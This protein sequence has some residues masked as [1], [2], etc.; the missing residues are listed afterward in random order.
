MRLQAHR[1]ASLEFAL[2]LLLGLLWG[3][4]YALTKISL[5]TIPPLSL[6][7]GRVAL[8]AAALWTVVAFR[9]RAIPRTQEFAA[10]LFIQGAL[11]C[12]LPYTLI[13]FGQQTVE[14]GLAAILNSATPV[15][16]CI[17]SVLW[18][19]QE[20]LSRRRIVGVVVGFSGVIGIT[21]A[22]ALLGFGQQVPGQAAIILA[23]LSSALSV[24]HGRHF[25]TVAPEVV[26]AGML[27]SAAALLLPL[28]LVLDV[29]WQ[30]TPSAASIAA[31]VVNALVATALGFVVYFR[32]IRTIGS[33]ATASTSYI[34]P[35]VGVL[36]GYVFL[37]EPLTWVTAGGLCAVLVGV[38]A[39]NSR[40]RLALTNNDGPN[41]RPSS[42]PSGSA[43]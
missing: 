3:S 14:S 6:V 33:I 28:C 4:P 8:A 37:A 25:E 7:A 41:M 20:M 2:V 29:P 9:R 21:G 42:D 5:E 22:S 23:T 32:L 36:I 18:A 30:T 43:V 16:V 35:A 13:A 26:A 24:I 38:A 39:I 11:S 27:T 31:L 12:V 10:R 15:F 40:P 1:V 17:I 19:H 34:K